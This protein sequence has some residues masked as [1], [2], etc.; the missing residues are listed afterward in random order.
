[1]KNLIIIIFTLISVSINAQNEMNQIFKLN[2]T[3][4]GKTFKHKKY[5][6]I[7]VNYNDDELDEYKEITTET[8]LKLVS[9]EIYEIRI[10]ASNDSSSVH[11]FIVHTPD[12]KHIKDSRNITVID[13]DLQSKG[14]FTI[15]EINEGTLFFNKNTD[16]WEMYDNSEIHF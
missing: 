13:I 2:F 6:M 7:V 12:L 4:N 9:S 16:R 14:R 1:M 11:R 8:L 10:K 5:D 15:N 3:F